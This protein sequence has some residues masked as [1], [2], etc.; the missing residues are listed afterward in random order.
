M[1]AREVF[2]QVMIG[3]PDT[4]PS[5]ATVAS[6]LRRAVG[7]WSIHEC[8]SLSC[9]ILNMTWIWFYHTKHSFTEQFLQKF[10]LVRLH[11]RRIYPLITPRSI[12]P[13]HDKSRKRIYP[14]RYPHVPTIH[15]LSK[16]AVTFFATTDHHK[17]NAS[18]WRLFGY[19]DSKASRSLFRLIVFRTLNGYFSF[20]W[21]TMHN[22]KF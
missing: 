5:I 15:Q 11:R 12:N 16:S 14:H 4:R 2:T 7:R 8:F 6:E 17:G 21:I 18:I 3:N 22:S 20:T 1:K 9:T 13:T 10:L 19:F